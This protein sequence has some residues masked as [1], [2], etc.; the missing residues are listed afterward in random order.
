MPSKLRQE[1]HSLLPSPCLPISRFPLFLN[2][3]PRTSKRFR[4]SAQRLF[5]E[6]REA[7]GAPLGVSVARQSH[8]KGT[9]KEL[10]PIYTHLHRAP[11]HPRY[12]LGG[13]RSPSSP[14]RA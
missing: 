7:P 11:R 10:R 5:R 13:A 6:T 8:S 2:F 14:S 9:L 1:R 12:P 3:L 4:K